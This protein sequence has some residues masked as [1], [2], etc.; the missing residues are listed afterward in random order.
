[1]EESNMTKN[2]L[3]SGLERETNFTL[4]ENGAVTHKSTLSGVVDWFAVGG[5]LRQRSEDDIIRIFSK[6]WS[7]DSL[8][9]LRILFYFRDVR[10][11]Q[12]ERN[13]F[14]ICLRWLANNHKQ[15]LIKNLQHI[16]FFGRWDDL[17]ALADTVLEPLVFEL[18]ELQL[19][20]DFSDMEKG[21]SVSLLAKWLKSEN[22]SSLESRRLALKTRKALGLSSKSYRKTLSRLRKY[23]DV[24]EV[25][26][27]QKEWGSIDYNTVPSQ[28]ATKYRKTFKRNDTERYSSYIDALVK[29]DGT[30]K[31][32]AGATFP[33]EILRACISEPDEKLRQ[34]LDAQWKVQPDW[35][36]DN[37]HKGLV[38]ADVSGSMTSNNNL[39]LLVAVSLA[40]YFAERNVGSFKDVFLTFSANPELTKIVGDS[41]YEKYFNMYKCDNWG[42]NTNLQAAFDL[43]LNTALKYRVSESDMPEVLYIVSDME[44]DVAQ[45]NYDYG[46]QIPHNTNYD[47]IRQKYADAG[48]KMPKIVFWNVN[49]RNDQ[50]PVTVNDDGV[51]LVSGCSPAIL[52][53]VLSAKT[54][55][56]LDVVDETINK[57]RYQRIVL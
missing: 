29:G 30:A 50:Q 26:L 56:P 41:L 12:G 21:E 4:T 20:Q 22:T 43:I 23:I 17:Y 36:K 24:V 13:T 11:G 48:Y 2:A 54:F 49:S 8:R 16:P 57:E 3:V 40:I 18:V 10:G 47:V 1:M 5:A 7:E 51:C 39:P 44:F 46:Q 37:P 25:K 32:N 14:R 53:S 15:A 35:L 55:N 33:Y 9:A 19:R 38:M 6:A 28:A 27:C 31:I 45:R 52:Q 42:Q 34:L